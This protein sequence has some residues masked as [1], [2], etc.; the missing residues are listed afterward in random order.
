MAAIPK[1]PDE[2]ITSIVRT[3]ND[4]R[5]A[6][7]VAKRGA[8]CMFIDPATGTPLL[9]FKANDTDTGWSAV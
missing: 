8:L 1:E 2:L 5:V 6:G 9:L 3:M 4:P 7:R